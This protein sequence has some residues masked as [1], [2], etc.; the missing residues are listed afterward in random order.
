MGLFCQTCLQT[1]PEG[2]KPCVDG[3]QAKAES[4][5][6]FTKGILNPQ[7][8]PVENGDTKPVQHA[9]C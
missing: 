7:T 6:Y 3:N 9:N 2:A 5:P 1:L 4:C 8:P